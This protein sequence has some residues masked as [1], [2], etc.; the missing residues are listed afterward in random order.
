MDP[1]KT[2]SK[3]TDNYLCSENNPSTPFLA[4][5]DGSKFPERT[6]RCLEVEVKKDF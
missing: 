1:Q 6:F 2:N 5:L 4:V 3:H